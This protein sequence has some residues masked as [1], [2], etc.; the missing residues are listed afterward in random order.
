[1]PHTVRRRPDPIRG[2]GAREGE[3]EWVSPRNLL[4]YTVVPVLGGES[5]LF[6]PV[7]CREALWWQPG[8]KLI[9]A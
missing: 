9:Q 7:L 2:E 8:E 6:C 3:R 5:T 1:M 4:W